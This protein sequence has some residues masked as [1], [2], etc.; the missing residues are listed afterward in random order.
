M[1]SPESLSPQLS[2][3]E[4]LRSSIPEEHRELFDSLQQDIKDYCK[5]HGLPTPSLTSREAFITAAQKNRTPPDVLNH[6]I[7]LLKRFDYL[8]EHKEPM[9]EEPI[10]L[11]QEQAREIMGR[12][13]L[14]TKEVEEHFG[15][16][17]LEQEE[18]LSI[19]P[20]SKETLEECKDT[21]ILVADIGLFILDIMK[22]ENCKKLF[23]EGYEWC[24]NHPFASYTEQ[25]SWRLI[26]KT[27]VEDSFDKTWK[28]Q[29]TL[30]DHQ[31]DE[32]PLARQVI[33]AIILHFFAT[34]ERLFR[35]F[36]VRTSD[37]DSHGDHVNLGVFDGDG[38]RISLWYNSDHGHLGLAS[39]RKS[40]DHLFPETT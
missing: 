36:Y 2:S 26:R 22:R 21:H 15:E 27:T 11:T 8:T 34:G 18:A 23:S 30:L 1:P 7:L 9:P 29:Q 31:I 16:L 19:I 6:I 10:S 38:L 25:P 32:I 3:V 40:E 28:E 12:N 33:Y 37:V 5:A 13:F 24:K 4:S 20:F 17:S 35:N 39:A 14:G